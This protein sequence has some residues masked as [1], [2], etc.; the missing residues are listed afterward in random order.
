MDAQ[1]RDACFC[2]NGTSWELCRR[3]RLVKALGFDLDY[4]M[5]EADMLQVCIVGATSLEPMMPE[6]ETI[7]PNISLFDIQQIPVQLAKFKLQ[8]VKLQS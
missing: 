8:S 3:E 7:R 5:P 2:S 4:N 1:P 6:H